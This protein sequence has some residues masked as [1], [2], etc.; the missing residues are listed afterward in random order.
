MRDNYTLF[1]IAINLYRADGVLIS[2]IDRKMKSSIW[3]FL[4]GVSYI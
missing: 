4:G 3:E 1:Q 2:W